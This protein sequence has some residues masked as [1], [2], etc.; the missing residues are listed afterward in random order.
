MTLDFSSIPYNQITW[1]ALIVIAI[2]LAAIA[3]KFFWHFIM[4]HVLKGCLVILVILAI[5]AV[6]RYYFHLF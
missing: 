4:R 5:L 3:I 2:I 1:G 6:L